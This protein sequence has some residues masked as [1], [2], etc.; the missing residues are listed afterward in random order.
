MFR[1]PPH[2]FHPTRRTDGIVASLVSLSQLFLTVNA[3][4]TEN[5]F[6]F[7]VALAASSL[8]TLFIV[9]HRADGGLLGEDFTR[10][11]TVL[12]AVKGGTQL[13][14]FLLARFVLR[15]FGFAIYKQAGADVALQRM[16]RDYLLFCSALRLDFV[17]AAALLLVGGLLSSGLRGEWERVAD[18]V[19]LAYS[20]AWALLG[21][22]AAVLESGA[23]LAGFALGGC[24]TPAYAAYR[25]VEF[26]APAS[27]AALP[28]G[29]GIAQVA[30]LGALALAARLGLAYCA[31]RVARNFSRGLRSRVFTRTRHSGALPLPPQPGAVG[32]GAGKEAPLLTAADA[33]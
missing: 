6:Q 15:R 17:F 32:A 9:W 21:W 12:V 18:G 28:A 33:L 29:F 10:W 11:S 14:Y 5:K 16:Y 30:V 4:L 20:A 2:L 25:L 8:S 23:L 13:A 19:A 22:Q 24:L 3:T 7:L 27:S 1:H 31:W 26:T